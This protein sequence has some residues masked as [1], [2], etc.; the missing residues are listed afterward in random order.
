MFNPMSVIL[1]YY[2]L[3]NF[4]QLKKISNS[5]PAAEPA[6]FSEMEEEVSRTNENVGGENAEELT[7]GTTK[8]IEALDNGA[9]ENGKE[10]SR[11]SA[12]QGK[13]RKFPS[14]EEKGKKMMFQ[15]REEKWKKRKFPSR[16]EISKARSKLSPC[17][18]KPLSV[19]LNNCIYTLINT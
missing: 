7:V 17:L 18:I 9:V 15:S 13:K 1:S 14:R 3:Q 6:E 16:E 5:K 2:Y 4:L 12:N 11:A 10:E 19:Q 8:E